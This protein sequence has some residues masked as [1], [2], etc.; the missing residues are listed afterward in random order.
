MEDLTAEQ[1]GEL[2]IGN[3]K[4]DSLLKLFFAFVEREA[5]DG[6]FSGFFYTDGKH[7]KDEESDYLVSLGY[8]IFW[9]SACLWYE[10]SW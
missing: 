4:E 10:V 5:E 6:K 1:A 8:K 2:A 3:M 9:N 7:F